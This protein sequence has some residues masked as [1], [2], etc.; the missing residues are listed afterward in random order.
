MIAKRAFSLIENQENLQRFR[1]VQSKWCMVTD[2]K[3]PSQASGY[4]SCHG[5]SDIEFSIRF[6]EH[7]NGDSIF[8]CRRRSAEFAATKS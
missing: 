6:R 3:T 7:R 1:V 2:A 8:C 4:C 5:S